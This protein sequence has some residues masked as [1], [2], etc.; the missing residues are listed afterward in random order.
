MLHIYIYASSTQIVNNVS[1]ASQDESD[2]TASK[3][4]AESYAAERGTS[5]HIEN[6]NKNRRILKI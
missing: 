2:H 6:V 3:K 4:Q 5:N 1:N